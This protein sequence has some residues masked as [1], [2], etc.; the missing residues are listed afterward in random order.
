MSRL[1]QSADHRHSLFPSL[2]P[3]DYRAEITQSEDS[4]ARITGGEVKN[5]GVTLSENKAEVCTWAHAEQATQFKRAVTSRQ[6]AKKGQA[7]VTKQ[8]DGWRMT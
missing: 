1:F 5:K 3:L 8:R 4:E 7:R 6:K 2:P